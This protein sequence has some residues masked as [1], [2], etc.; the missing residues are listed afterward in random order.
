MGRRT[1]AWVGAVV[2]AATVTLG[3]V[4]PAQADGIVGAALVSSGVTALYEMN[5]A[6]GTTVMLD[7]SGN[8]NDGVVDPTG[9]ESGGV[10]DGETGYNWVYRPPTEPPVSPE[11]VVQVP[12]DPAGSLEPTGQDFTLEVRVRFTDK[13]GNIIQ[14]GQS[15]TVGGQWK[16]QAPSGVPSCLFKGS[17]GQVATQAKGALD[18]GRWHNLA[19][20]LTSSGVTMYVD[21]EY[22][23]TKAGDPGL[24]D[25]SLPMTVGGKINC[26]QVNVTCDY[27]T[28]QIDRIRISKGPNATPAASFSGDCPGLTCS[29]DATASSDSDGDV[30]LYTWDFGDGGVGTGAH[31]T[32]IYAADGTYRVKL[33]VTDNRGGTDVVFRDVTAAGIPVVSQV[34]YVDSAVGVGNTATPTVVIP[35]TAAPGDRLLLVMSLNSIDRTFT[36]PTGI[37]DLTLLD[38]VIAKTMS[39]TVWTKTL[40][41]GDPGTTVTVPLVGGL[42]KYNLTAA[43]YSGVADV[44]SLQFARDTGVVN[45]TVRL[46]PQVSG[47]ADGSWVVSYWADRSSATTVWTPSSEVVTRSTACGTTSARIC[48]A[49]ADSDAKVP[50]VYGNISATTTVVSPVATMWSIVLPTAEGADQAPTAAF[51]SNC[52]MLVCAF[53]PSGSSDPEG[54]LASYAWDFGDGETST[55]AAPS[56][57]FAAAGDYDVTLTVTDAGG[58][59]DTVNHVVSVTDAAPPIAFVGAA[60][61]VSA[62]AKVTVTVPSEVGVHDRLLLVMSANST[63]R[64]FTGPPGWT[65]LDTAL[66]NTMST[67]VWTKVADGADA[68]STVTV[69]FSAAVKATLT[70]SAYS[71]TDIAGLPVFATSATTDNVTAR[72][73]PAVTVPVNAWVVSHWADKSG[74]TSAWSTGEATARQ[75]ACAAGTGR[76]CSLLADSGG[77]VS[78]SYGP[79]TASTDV[80]SNKAVMWSIVLRPADAENQPPVAGFA[81]DCQQLACSFDASASSDPEG[82]VASY[83]WDFGDGETSSQLQ[84]EHTFGAAGSYDVTLTVTDAQGLTDAITEQ[85]VVDDQA[86]PI[87]F[88][89]SAATTSS[90]ANAGVTVPGGV[91]AG[92]RLLLVL[93]VNSTNQT[94]TG[95]AGWTALDTTVGNTMS[96]TVWTKVAGS[97]D[98]GATAAVSFSGAVKTTLTVAAYRGTDPGSLPTFATA[99]STSNVTARQAPAVTV[100]DGGWVVT[101]WADKSGTTSSWSTA[102]AA[103]RQAPCA[104]GSGRVCSLL[105]DSGGPVS[106]GYGPVTASTDLASNKA[107]MWSIVLAPLT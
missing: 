7:S 16:I 47:V 85:V 3:M 28:G 58:L 23:S 94:F 88:V 89:A 2:G 24:I 22:Q 15:A 42:T 98:A 14:K 99:T 82:P 41:E 73:A 71:G 32:H 74:T 18:D 106:G 91:A 25:N 1:H 104:S 43:V 80:A 11:R 48:S 103:A 97:S 107:V 72:P 9:V 40:A 21:G 56:H 10:Y 34:R 90:T 86:P 84:P 105:A 31:P 36:G 44:S 66:G 96:T 76:I 27:Y 63:S 49:L 29:F 64:T 53:D 17:L 30:A 59:T 102:E 95:P 54:A 70:V 12:D 20:V 8:G 60:V 100:P 65:K 37:T 26:D 61:G 50:E 93:S 5:E 4:T 68:G 19:C 83:A 87:A 62:T 55:E 101:H 46:T 81:S 78:G 33:T 75:A 57:T 92:D 77:P 67:T 6:P 69:P 51:G 39:T 38:T 45:D 35:A 52:L 79:I 13:F